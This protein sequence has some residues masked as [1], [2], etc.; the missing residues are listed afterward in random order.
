MALRRRVVEETEE[1][2]VIRGEP[3]ALTAAATAVDLTAA[4][5]QSLKISDQEWQREAW[6]LYDVIGEFR[7]SANR[8][9]NSVSRARFYI[10]EIDDMGMP[11]K[12][13]TDPRIAVIAQTMFGGPTE[14][15]ESIRTMGIAH[16]VAGECYV[17]AEDAENADKDVWYVISPAEIKRDA[18]GV[19]VT[20]P[21]TVGGGTHTLRPKQDLLIRS[22][23]PHPRFANVADS[24]ARSALPVLREIEQLAKLTFSQIDSRLISAGIMFLP[25]NLSFPRKDSDGNTVSGNIRDLADMIMEA[26]QASLTGAGSAA[27]LVPILVDVPEG[28]AKDIVH[29]RFDTPLTAE[30]EKKIEQAIRRLALSLDMNPET[31][32]GLGSMNHW[33]A[34]AVSEDEIKTHIEPILGRLVNTL[35]IGY[36]RPALTALGLDP[37]KYCLW[38]DTSPLAVRPNR[39]EDALQLYKLGV[40]SDEE[41]RKA[42]NFGDEAVPGKKD[43]QQWMAWQ[44]LLANPQLATNP[45]ILKLV[46]LPEEVATAAQQAAQQ[47]MVP[48]GAP[49]QELP[50]GQTNELPEQPTGGPSPAQAGEEDF[51]ALLPGAE[52]AVLRALEVA[53]AKLVSGQYGR[54]RYPEVPKHEI[55]T[56]VG[57]VGQERAGEL[58]AGAFAASSTVLAKHFRANPGEV[59]ALLEGYAVELLARGVPHDSDLLDT[60]LR[61]ARRGSVRS[62]VA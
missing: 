49:R 56:R 60:L 43:H 59:E 53:G 10:A 34:W 18:D 29:M 55:H 58:V 46:G 31:L 30:I 23:T 26:A 48:G 52:L 45:E 32:T 57:G 22:L 47:A 51:G 41:L 19:K 15:V 54:N 37:E 6:R 8:Y 61:R 27:G 25:K 17:V 50:P 44:L 39:F 16:F 4:G 9:G 21:Q 11:A 36:V 62:M 12:E 28:T 35:T 2:R 5:V 24:P 13:V 1:P 33:S 3:R 7:F 38:Y 42:G 40:L 14:R 20:R